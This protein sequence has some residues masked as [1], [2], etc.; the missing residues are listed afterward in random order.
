VSNTAIPVEKR[1]AENPRVVSVE[2]TDGHSLILR[3]D[4]GER[5]V[6][7]VTPLLSVGRFRSLA[8]VEEFRK[9]RVAYDSVEWENGLDLDPEY[10]YERSRAL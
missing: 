3:F 5:R 10:L 6:F 4:N 2:A 8:A 7:D 1:I 9:V